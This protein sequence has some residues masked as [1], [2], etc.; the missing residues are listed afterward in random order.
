MVQ[1]Y[2]S[3]SECNRL[4]FLS[5]TLK[6]LKIHLS[7]LPAMPFLQGASLLTKGAFILSH[8]CSAPCWCPRRCREGERIDCLKLVLWDCLKSMCTSPFQGVSPC[9]SEL[10]QPLA[11]WGSTQDANSS[12]PAG[13]AAGLEGG[14]KG[15]GSHRAQQIV[16]KI[17]VSVSDP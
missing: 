5:C 1:S 13:W 10:W 14:Y 12:C 2:S 6:L 4:F 8:V 9:F 11:S 17:S 7:P 16:F 3:S 15:P